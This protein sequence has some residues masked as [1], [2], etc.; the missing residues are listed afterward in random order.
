MGS[1]SKKTTEETK[2]PSWV[3][4]ASKQAVSMGQRIADRDYE[5]FEGQRVADLSGNEAM[6][7]EKARTGFGSANDYFD[8][9][10]QALSGIQS[11]VDADH[12]AWM[13][14]Y[15]QNVVDQ[16]IRGSGR[17]F[18]QQRSELKRTSAMRGAFG[19]GRQT[20]MEGALNRDQLENT[21]D[22][23]GA[24]YAAAYDQGQRTFQDEQQRKIAQGG[25][26]AALGSSLSN[27][28]SQQIESLQKTGGTE[29][30]IEQA[31]RNFEYAQFIEKR[32]WDVTNL[33]PLLNSIQSAKHG[34]T[35]KTTEKTSGGGLSA[36][37]GAAMV[38][39]GV[40]TANPLMVKGGTAIG[41]MGG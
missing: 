20:A 34:E 27:T 36:L 17:A 39:G 10:A 13:N 38:V 32:D 31:N 21:G 29:R 11:W 9:G 25:A 23:Y 37:A 26:F 16:Q 28:A 8:K 5:G 4:D 30:E 15:T 41:G 2:L 19:G 33:Q 1:K 6:A 24:G 40:M 14:P 18:D 12:S 3:T 35:K 7:S 22:I